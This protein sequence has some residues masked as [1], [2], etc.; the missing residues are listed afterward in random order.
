MF[1]FAKLVMENLYEQTSRDNL[2]VELQNFPAGLDEAYVFPIPYN[3]SH[4]YI[5]GYEVEDML[6]LTNKNS[7]IIVSSYVSWTEEPPLDRLMQ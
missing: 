3:L 5:S 2:L 7:D 1:L 4:I 6:N